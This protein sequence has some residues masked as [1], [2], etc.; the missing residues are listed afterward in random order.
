MAN[1]ISVSAAAL[2]KLAVVPAEADR[3]F[4]IAE[5]DPRTVA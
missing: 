1:A 4:F 2:T 3:V 5:L